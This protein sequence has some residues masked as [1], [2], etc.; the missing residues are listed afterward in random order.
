MSPGRVLQLLGPSTGGMRAHV[1]ALRA[2]LRTRGW[3]VTT[4]GPSGVLDGLDHVVDVGT[5]LGLVR[6][7]SALRRAAVGVD[8]VHAHGQKAGW[9]A[10][11]ARLRAPVVVTAHNVV[12]SDAL[13]RRRLEAALPARVAEVIATSQAV[14]ARLGTD[15][16]IPPFGPDPVVARSRH[17][18]RAA[19]GVGDEQ[20]LVVTVARLHPQKGLDTLLDAVASIV[21]AVPGLAV[22]V[23]GE[24]PLAAELHRRRAV[25]NLETVVRLPGARPHAIDE[26]AAADVVAI[27]SV[28]E[29]GPLVASEA[30]ALG[31]P[32]VS[33]PVGFVPDLVDDGHSARLVPVGDAPA[34][35]AAVRELLADPG[36]AAA[37]GAAGQRRVAEHLDPDRLVDAIEATYASVLV[38]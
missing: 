16:I 37:L 9:L 20:P 35:A 8:V 30:L 38:S 21:A 36:A 7:W 19:L 29:S 13:F 27:A 18:V 6:G 24:G 26:L 3:T 1:M 25:L 31:R 32:L 11:G 15:R 22:A 33:T 28:W 4:A 34:L 14:A 12:L 2:R 5:P 10:A 17:D 23:I